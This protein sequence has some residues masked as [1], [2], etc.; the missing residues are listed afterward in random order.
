MKK[1]FIIAT[2]GM[3][4]FASCSS[5]DANKNQE[6]VS[7]IVA[8]DQSE[9]EIKAE[10]KR[11]L[12]EEKRIQASLTT[13][14]VDKMEH[15]FGKIKEDTENPVTFWVTNTGKQPLIIDKVDVSCGCTTAA[16]P[17]QPILP[18]QKDK[19]EVV[20]HPKVGQLN[21]QSKTVTLTANT[22][23]KSHVVTIKAFVE[24]K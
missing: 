3:F 8:E 12:E 5:N 18:G 24:K 21:E 4:I 1:T 13:L 17:E 7:A 19:I 15:D 11:I 23:E 9:E 10:Q 22:A 14:K 16:K 20:F 2:C 6:V